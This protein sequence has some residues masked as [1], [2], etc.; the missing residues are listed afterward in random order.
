MLLAHM[1]TLLLDY[2]VA[3]QSRQGCVSRSGGADL[4]HRNGLP[5]SEHRQIY[6]RWPRCSTVHSACI[7]V[8]WCARQPTPKV[9][10]H[11]SC[12]IALA[13]VSSTMHNFDATRRVYGSERGLQIQN[14][15]SY[16]RTT[17]GYSR[18]VIHLFAY[19]WHPGGEARPSSA[20][21]V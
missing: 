13:L 19:Y 20:R 12:N 7:P 14:V 6:A 10:G 5:C 18:V 8:R 2:K 3:A 17:G 16:S 4:R 9:Q 15:S 1:C 21:A 11:L